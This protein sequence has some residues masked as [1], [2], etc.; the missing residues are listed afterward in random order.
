MTRMKMHELRNKTKM[1]LLNQLKDMKESERP[2]SP[3]HFQQ[4]LQD[5]GA[6][7]TLDHI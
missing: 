1:K 5:Q 3:T 2:R 6:K 7:P 4:A